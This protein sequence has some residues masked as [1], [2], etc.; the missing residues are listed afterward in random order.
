[1][2]HVYHP[3][4]GAATFTDTRSHTIASS[5]SRDGTTLYA[6]SSEGH[7]AVM[8]FELSELGHVAPPDTAVKIFPK[9]EYTKPARAPSGH[10]HGHPASATTGTAGRP[11]VL[12]ARKGPR[13]EASASSALLPIPPPFAPQKITVNKD[14]KRRI[15]PAFLGLG[16]IVPQPITA[17]SSASALQQTQQ[18]S[19]LQAISQS[20]PSTGR[21]PVASTSRLPPGGVF[22]PAFSN[23]S[24]GY[25]TEMADANAPPARN[26]VSVRFGSSWHL[27]STG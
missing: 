2:L 5:R 4:C 27:T 11:N 17:T 15:Q 24:N 21:Q 25:D 7:I 16:G 13:K 26:R 8:H 22:Q 18:Q 3:T 19:S 14:G 23:Y 10:A 12:M 6:C 20:H 9:W 1:M